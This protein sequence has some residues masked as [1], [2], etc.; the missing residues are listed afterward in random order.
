MPKIF[1]DNYNGIL[2]DVAA[3]YANDITD[4][5]HE[6]DAYV[7]WQDVRGAHRQNA[8]LFRR[9]GKPVIVYQHGRGA[10]RDYGPPNNFALLADKILVW[11]EVERMRLMRYGVPD[12][13]IAV[14]GCPLFSRL[15]PKDPKRPGKNVLFVP[16]IAE[17]EAPENI[18]VYSELKIWESKKLQEWVLESMAKLRG[19]WAHQDNQYRLV[20]G[21]ERLWSSTVIPKLPRYITYSKGLLNVKLTG[22]HDQHQ[23]MSPIA[24]T[25]QNDPHHIDALADLLANTDVMVCLEEGTMQLLACAL[26]I[27]IIHV[28][29]FKYGTYGGTANYDTVE[30]IAT[31]ATYRLKG[32]SDLANTLDYALEHPSQKRK[33]RIVACEQ[34]GGAHLGS[35]LE[36]A[37]KAIDA[38]LGQKKLI[39]I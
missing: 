7:T 29:I 10:V 23:Y 1:L 4:N 13:K 9:Q 34:E 35:P 26:D 32:I 31:P 16:V 33:E 27:P 2:D 8:E 25:N 18:L 17:G 39:Q 14:V 28:D 12:H 22:V 24:M 36:N 38:H 3:Y 30:K 20:N 21:Q 15:K 19:S 11:G 37:I 6:A 5:Q